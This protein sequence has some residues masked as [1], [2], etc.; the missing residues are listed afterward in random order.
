[1]AAALLVVW[2]LYLHGVSFVVCSRPAQRRQLL[3]TPS[4][5]FGVDR[6]KNVRHGQHKRRHAHNQWQHQQQQQPR[7]HH[8]RQENVQERQRFREPTWRASANISDRSFVEQEQTMQAN[9]S[10]S[11]ESIQSRQPEGS[12]LPVSD[13]PP[14]TPIGKASE[15]EP[16]PEPLSPMKAHEI[17]PDAFDAKEAKRANRRSGFPV[18]M[19]V[20]SLGMFISYMIY[21][22]SNVDLQ[23]QNSSYRLISICAA[24]MLSFLAAR[25][26]VS[27]VKG[28]GEVMHIACFAYMMTTLGVV[29]AAFYVAVSFRC[30]AC[31]GSFEGLAVVR[32]VGTH[33]AAFLA[34]EALTVGQDHFIS[35]GEGGPPEATDYMAFCIF[36]VFCLRAMSHVCRRW[37]A[38]KRDDSAGPRWA[39]VADESEDT[40]SGLA[41]GFIIAKTVTFLATKRDRPLACPLTSCEVREDEISGLGVAFIVAIT[42]HALGGRLRAYLAE[43]ACS[44]WEFAE[45]HSTYAFMWIFIFFVA[46]SCLGVFR[47]ID[48][49]DYF[50]SDTVDMVTIAFVSSP[51][52]LL[53]VWAIGRANSS[54]AVSA[55]LMKEALEAIGLTVGVLWGRALF[56]CIDVVADS[57]ASDGGLEYHE[58]LTGFVTLT[59]L[60]TPW[61]AWRV[62]ILPV[63][64]VDMPKRFGSLSADMGGTDQV[65]TDVA[66]ETGGLDMLGGPSIDAIAT[67]AADHAA[68]DAA[69]AAAAAASANAAAAT[70]IAAASALTAAAAAQ[71]NT[72]TAPTIAIEPA[73]LVADAPVADAIAVA[74]SL[75]A[76]ADA[77]ACESAN[78]DDVREDLGD[79]DIGGIGTLKA[80]ETL[81]DNTSGD[82]GSAPVSSTTDA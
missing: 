24:I 15:P 37:R 63:A 23:I 41:N 69:A 57:L 36:A 27:L 31:R 33:V 39:E 82:V 10:A 71:Q 6:R 26:L 44:H 29:A 79:T 48:T 47:Q 73:Q 4:G 74:A 14:N 66:G 53:G 42:L 30:F 61:L 3:L 22:L 54:V 13:G 72:A 21:L 70:A 67:E 78:G 25:S 51:I 76:E 46:D 80:D 5:V 59:L 64:A 28:F 12:V 1:M 43:T 60:A 16:P 75:E 8:A 7:R 34:I 32:T 45:L 20:L 19:T 50:K 56:S 65:A 55:I 18:A 52:L 17:S 58:A 35:H 40:I 62:Y 11:R 68:A 81:V 38:S 2:L 77:N 9:L 49:P